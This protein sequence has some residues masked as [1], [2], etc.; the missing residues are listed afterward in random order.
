MPYG[1]NISDPKSSSPDASCIAKPN[2]ATKIVANAASPSP[3][4]ITPSDDAREDT[5]RL[6]IIS[7]APSPFPSSQSPT[8]YT[9]PLIPKSNSTSPSENPDLSS[10]PHDNNKHLV[11]EAKDIMCETPT[12]EPPDEQ[13]SFTLLCPIKNDKN[14]MV[15]ISRDFG[16]ICVWNL[17]AEK[18]I[19]VLKGVTQPR[20]IRMIDQFKALVLCNRELKVFNL[21]SGKLEVKLKGMMNQKMPFFGIQNEKYVVA[22]SRNRMYV[23][24]IN[25]K[26]GDLET[27]F[28]VGEDRFLNSLLVS[29]NGRVCV[30]GDETQKVQH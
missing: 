12:P 20:D 30:C 6:G 10:F 14:H 15:S 11:V 13:K 27:T 22:L 4:L 2:G 26:T 8:P 18:P 16:E 5:S 21:D 9:S 7:S 28:K 1:I 29:S 3:A 19:R 25:L 17:R 23:N 24:L